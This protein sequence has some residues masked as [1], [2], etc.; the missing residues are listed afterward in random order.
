[1]TALPYTKLND[2]SVAS[3]VGNRYKLLIQW[4][5]YSEPTYEWKS[6]I[7]SQ[8]MNDELLHEIATAIDKC[9]ESV[10]S[11]R[12]EDEDPRIRL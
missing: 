9:K 2:Y 10:D 4:K 6:D 8:T 7:A 12:S 1:M 5:G 11:S 3:K